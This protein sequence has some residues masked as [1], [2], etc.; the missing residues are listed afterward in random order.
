MKVVRLT[1]EQVGMIEKSLNRIHGEGKWKPTLAYAL[2]EAA[3]VAVRQYHLWESIFAGEL[4]VDF[5]PMTG[6][7]LVMNEKEAE[8][9]HAIYN[10]PDDVDP[11]IDL[12]NKKGEFQA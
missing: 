12:L 9:A 1:D 3:E 7:P 5:I 2:I 11:V 10:K 4:Y 8:K 6:Q